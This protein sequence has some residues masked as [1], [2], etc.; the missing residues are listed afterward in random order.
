MCIRDSSG[1]DVF[2]LYDTYGFPVDLIEDIV[3]ETDYTLDMKAYEEEMLNQKNSSKKASKF[4]NPVGE[5][6]DLTRVLNLNNVTKFV[7][8]DYLNLDTKILAIIKDDEIVSSATEKEKIGIILESSP[9]YA[10]SGGQIGDKGVIE[11]SSS[12]IDVFDTQ[13]TKEGFF[14]HSGIVKKGEVKNS[15]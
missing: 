14:I 10:E 3:S 11:T 5:A 15:D 6:I 7:G 4:K 9:F 1:R 8:Y 12:I 2:K 13:K